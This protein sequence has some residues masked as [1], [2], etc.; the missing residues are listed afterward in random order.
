MATVL[1]IRHGRT[2]ANEQGV[3]AGTAGGTLL[4]DTGIAQASAIGTG[5]GLL[6]PNAIISSPLERTM[7]TASLI[8]EGLQQAD[9]LAYSI[10]QEPKL[11]ECNYGDWTGKQLSD[12][13]KEELWRAV[14]DH[15][16]SVTFPGQ[17][18]ESL[19][20]MQ[21]RA[22]TAI[23]HWNDV[24]GPEALYIAVSHG[25]V[26]KSIIADALGTHLDHF[27]RIMI[28]PGS[29]SVIRY[30]SMRPFVLTTNSDAS[31][32]ERFVS[33]SQENSSDAPVG[34]GTS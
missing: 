17:S 26:I 21:S 19:A 8:A 29:V 24:L 33:A 15:P 4:D 2:H 14:Q 32:I 3:L 20:A 6:K 13:T 7:Q 22:V 23:R 10:V 1:L 11:I 25:D 16:S 12:L 9:S 31:R 28:D 5:L 30:S 34:G 27:Q 18:G